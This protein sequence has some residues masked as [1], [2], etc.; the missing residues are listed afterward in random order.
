MSHFSRQIGPHVEAELR[1]AHA[2]EAHAK[3]L[4]AFTH[5]ERAHVLGQAATWLHMR[6]HVQMFLW[7][8]RQRQ[9]KECVGQVLRLAGAAVAT[10]FGLLPTGNTGGANISAFKPLPI[11]PELAALIAQAQTNK[12]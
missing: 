12:N 4:D 8:W 3:I 10:P 2:D 6:V 9:L 1:A 5:L 7:A 11:A